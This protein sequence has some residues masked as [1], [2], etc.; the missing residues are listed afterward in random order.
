MLLLFIGSYK[1][2]RKEK[3]RKIPSTTGGVKRVIWI[4][5]LA[6]FCTTKFVVHLLLKS[7]QYENLD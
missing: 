7:A 4:S 2:N 5:M 3:K 6:E 1:R